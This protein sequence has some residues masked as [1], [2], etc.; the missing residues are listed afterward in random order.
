M[1]AQRR[2]NS[3]FHFRAFAVRIPTVVTR[4]DDDNGRGT[5]EREEVGM[6]GLIANG[7]SPYAPASLLSLS[8]KPAA[9]S[10]RLARIATRPI[11]F[12]GTEA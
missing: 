5:A 8:S 3:S 9:F 6:K 4:N 10:A 12:T 2:N 7:A 11:S 1:L